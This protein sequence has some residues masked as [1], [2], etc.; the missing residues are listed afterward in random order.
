MWGLLAGEARQQPPHL[1]VTT[2][3]PNDP[4]LIDKNSP[5]S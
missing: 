2:A 3:T 5:L 4:N 1:P